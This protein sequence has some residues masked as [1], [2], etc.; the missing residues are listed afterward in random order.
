L[1]RKPAKKDPEAT[2]KGSTWVSTGLFAIVLA[3]GLALAAYTLVR[4]FL[5][6]EWFH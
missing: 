3:V 5:P 2:D 6:K 1:Q 4:P